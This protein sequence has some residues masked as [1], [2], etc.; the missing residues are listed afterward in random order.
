MNPI[1]K[2]IQFIPRFRSPKKTKPVKKPPPEI[3][4]VKLPSDKVS[5]VSFGS[6]P[7]ASG[8]DA[9]FY[10]ANTV[11]SGEHLE[12]TI[13]PQQQTVVLRDLNSKNGSALYYQE[14]GQAKKFMI[15]AGPRTDVD[16]IE[17][18]WRRNTEDDDMGFDLCDPKCVEET[19]P[20][21]LSTKW[22]VDMGD[23]ANCL[24]TIENTGREI[25]YKERI[26]GGPDRIHI[27]LQHN[28]VPEQTPPDNVEVENKK[29]SWIKAKLGLS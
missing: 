4:D 7:S 15:L 23:L 25:I 26:A 10:S 3:I 2:I 6:N 8:K 17:G 16:G 5:V 11:V 9:V 20:L 29:I 14:E 12:L 21:S 28:T 19:D 18:S 22:T 27:L 13:D 24:E 1:G